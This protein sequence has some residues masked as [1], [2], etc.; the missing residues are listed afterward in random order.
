[1]VFVII[2]LRRIIHQFTL[3]SLTRKLAHSH[4]TSLTLIVFYNPSLSIKSKGSSQGLVLYGFLP[5]FSPI[6]LLTHST[7]FQKLWEEI[8]IS[9][10]TILF[11]TSYMLCAITTL[12]KLQLHILGRSV[13]KTNP[14]ISSS[15]PSSS[16][17]TSQDDLNDELPI[18][19]ETF[20][21]LIEGTYKQLFG[22]GIRTFSVLVKERISKELAT[23]TVSSKLNVEYPELL[24]VLSNVRK[25]I[26]VDFPAI[27]QM[28]FIPR[29][30]SASSNDSDEFSNNSAVH[31]A[32]VKRLLAE[33]WDLIECPTFCE[34]YAESVDICFGVV[35][36]EL[37]RNIFKTSTT[38]AGFGTEE[39]S[40]AL[41]FCHF[42]ASVFLYV[43]L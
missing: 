13:Y 17:S 15:A 23:W 36:D 5:F 7:L 21:D 39:V 1:V 4:V 35:K 43:A 16:S 38:R 24:H 12:L 9:S 42:V 37:E 3:H 18:D 27:M 26:E 30:A 28:I 40:E 2:L 14:S 29:E 22:N 6:I 20:R 41:V 25:N 33:T 32:T 31:S 8:K 19:S 34:A 10:F 11:V